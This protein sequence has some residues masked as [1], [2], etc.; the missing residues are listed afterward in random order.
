MKA[1]KR[2]LK[3]S[4]DTR[5][6]KE[7]PRR[8]APTG[9]VIAF[10]AGIGNDLHRMVRGRK[11]I[12]GGVHIP[13]PKGPEGHSDGDVPGACH[14]RRALRSRRAGRH[15]PS[16]SQLFSRVARRFEPPVPSARPQAAR[17]RR[18]HH[19]QRR[20]HGRPRAPKLSP[21]IPGM[22]EK[23]ARALG[24]A[25]GQVS[26]KA[27]T[28]EGVDAVGRGQAVRADAVALVARRRR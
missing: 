9:G 19:R 3:P 12:L 23:L 11:L 8:R 17:R 2:A 13:F 27:K 7:K 22:Q 20:C 26:V 16:F 14:L 6:P 10:R 4:P 24:L 15:W 1:A 18:L 28:G 5:Q 25:P 21:H